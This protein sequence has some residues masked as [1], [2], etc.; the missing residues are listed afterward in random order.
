[1]FRLRPAYFAVD[2]FVDFFGR[3]SLGCC[4]APAFLSVRNSCVF[5]LYDLTETY[6]YGAKFYTPPPP[7]PENTLLGVGGG[8]I[9]EGGAYKILP[10]GASEYTPPPPFSEKG[11]LSKRGVR[12]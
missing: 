4:F 7:D 9:K 10:R 5:V 2:I 3:P 1:M 8:V 11:L 6:V 12:V